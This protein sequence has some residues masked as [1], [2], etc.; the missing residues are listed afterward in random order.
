MCYHFEVA[1]GLDR[2]VELAVISLGEIEHAVPLIDPLL[3][4]SFLV[5]VLADQFGC[6][7]VLS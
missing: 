3:H 5:L 2:V 4:V 1:L 6:L 7:S